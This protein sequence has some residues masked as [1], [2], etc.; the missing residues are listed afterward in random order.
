MAKEREKSFELGWGK[1]L[2]PWRVLFKMLSNV[3][4]GGEGRF[5]IAIRLASST[6]SE[7]QVKNG[8]SLNVV[9]RSLAV[10]SPIRIIDDCVNE[11]KC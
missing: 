5:R 8:A 4:Q 7:D 9:I 2:I 11:A 10:V 3:V 1:L 6:E